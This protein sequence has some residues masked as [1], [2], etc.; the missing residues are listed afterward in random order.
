[1][2]AFTLVLTMKQATWCVVLCPYKTGV[3]HMQSEGGHQ[4]CVGLPR[5]GGKPGTT[6]TTTTKIDTLWLPA[7]VCMHGLAHVATAGSFEMCSSDEVAL[8]IFIFVRLM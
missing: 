5:K 3:T 6:T 2:H 4:P 8:A 7:L 1:M